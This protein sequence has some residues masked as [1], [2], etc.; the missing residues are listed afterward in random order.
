MHFINMIDSDVGVLQWVENLKW[1]NIND[2]KKSERT[3]VVVNGIIEGYQKAFGNF[4]FYWVNRAG[5]MV[6]FKILFAF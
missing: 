6:I 5:H 2:W 3:P 4:A 1:K